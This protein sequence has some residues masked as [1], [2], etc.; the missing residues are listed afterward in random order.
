M[1][2]T[3]SDINLRLAQIRDTMLRTKWSSQVELEL[4]IIPMIDRLRADIVEEIYGEAADSTERESG[5][6]RENHPR[7]TQVWDYPT[8]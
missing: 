8:G 5:D 4:Q 2:L 6:V 1:T 7:G 3:K